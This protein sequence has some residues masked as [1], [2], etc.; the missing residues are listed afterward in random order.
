MFL[1]AQIDFY[2]SWVRPPNHTHTH[3]EREKALEERKSRFFLYA[4]RARTRCMSPHQA[5]L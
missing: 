4:D 1:T 5:G 3:R 2:L